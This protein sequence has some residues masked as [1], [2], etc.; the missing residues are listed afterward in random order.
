MENCDMCIGIAFKG[1][2]F[3]LGV[4]P[5]P[6]MSKSAGYV[7]ALAAAGIEYRDFWQRMITKAMRRRL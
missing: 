7:R 6:D 3:I 4:N 1:K 5:N 2:I